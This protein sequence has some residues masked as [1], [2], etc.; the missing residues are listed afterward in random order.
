MIRWASTVDQSM[1]LAL[2][3]ILSRCRIHRGNRFLLKKSSCTT[4]VRNPW[5]DWWTV[6]FSCFVDKTFFFAKW[7]NGYIHL[8]VFFKYEMYIYIYYTTYIFI[9]R[10][11]IYMFFLNDF[12]WFFMI[13]YD[14]L[15]FIWFYLI[16]YDYIHISISISNI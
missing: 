3:K 12:I 11:S 13:L 5:N 4:G 1:I 2:Q 15:W 6:S 14:F 8:G 10:C 16:L 9:H 7:Q